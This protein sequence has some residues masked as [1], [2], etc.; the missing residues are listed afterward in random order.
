M[1]KRRRRCFGTDETVRPW[2]APF[3]FTT[4]L[5]HRENAFSRDAAQLEALGSRDKR[6]WSA[7]LARSG[8]S[9]PLSKRIT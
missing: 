9:Q 5:S 4:R 3:F 8:Y 1:T 7:F 2:I 6:N